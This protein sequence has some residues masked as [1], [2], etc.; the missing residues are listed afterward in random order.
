MLKEHA[1]LS[2]RGSSFVLVTHRH[3]GC[4][5]CCVNFSWGHPHG[6]PFTQMGTNS[7]LKWDFTEV[8]L[9]ET[10]EFIKC[11]F[12]KQG[13]SERLLT[14]ACVTPPPIAKSP[15]RPTSSWMALTFQFYT[16]QRHPRSLETGG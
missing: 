10:N 5:L 7:R 13:A 11:F 2:C 9:F 1:N 6:H 14:R 8:Q 16:V 3:K 15:Q 12:F 4:R